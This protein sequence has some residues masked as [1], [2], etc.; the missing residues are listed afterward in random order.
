MIRHAELT[1]HYRF[2][3][4]YFLIIMRYGTFYSNDSD[5]Y[6]DYHW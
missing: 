4:F 1:N 2:K 5:E 6:I 3:Y